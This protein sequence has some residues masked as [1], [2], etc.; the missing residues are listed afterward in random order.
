MSEVWIGQWEYRDDR[1]GGGTKALIADLL[2]MTDEEA[3][4]AA[5]ALSEREEAEV[6]AK[7]RAIFAE[8]DGK[9]AELG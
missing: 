8:M 4:R 9:V 3:A 2:M 7:I 6:T 5:Q 1:R